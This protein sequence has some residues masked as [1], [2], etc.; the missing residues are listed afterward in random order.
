MEGAPLGAGAVGVSVTD[1]VFLLLPGVVTVLL[2]TLLGYVRVRSR[3]LLRDAD[4]AEK[5][6]RERLLATQLYPLLETFYSRWGSAMASLARPY[7]VEAAPPTASAVTEAAVARREVLHEIRAELEEIATPFLRIAILKLERSLS[8][9]LWQATRVIA[10]AAL[11]S[12]LLWVVIYCFVPTAA[13]RLA[14]V[15][16]IGLTVVALG[17]VWLNAERRTSRIERANNSV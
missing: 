8:L 2:M 15:G 3:D 6:F 1:A 5:G 13:V 14:Y 12:H 4:L 7:V 9:S 10:T 11:L 17:G 16:F